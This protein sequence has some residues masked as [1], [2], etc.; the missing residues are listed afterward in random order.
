MR[1][2][3]PAPAIPF[4]FVNEPVGTHTSRTMMLVELRGLLAMVGPEG[5]YEAYR[6]AAVELNAV[7]KATESTRRKTFR[8]LRELY[9]LSPEIDIFRALRSVWDADPAEQPIIAALCATARDPV[10]RATADQILALYID[11]EITPAE[12]NAGVLAAF[13][14]RYSPGVAA[15]TA[16]SIASS[17]QQAGLLRGRERKFRAQPYVGPAST[18][19]SLYLGHLCGARGELLFSTLWARMLDRPIPELRTLAAVAS[20]HG[21]LEYREAGGVTDVTFRHFETRP[22][23]E[24]HD[25]HD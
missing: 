17:W 21:W 7:R 24:T 22:R 2:Q 4:G 14:G 12:L 23:D 8:H 19:Y 18:A 16:R 3:L 20:R 13:P 1:I 25:E 11:Q 6:T 5:V 9:G 15:R 10:L